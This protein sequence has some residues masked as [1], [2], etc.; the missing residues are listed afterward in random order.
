LKVTRSEWKNRKKADLLVLP[1]WEGPKGAFEAASWLK[2]L[3]P[4][5]SDFKGKL[6]E[7]LLVYVDEERVLLLGL[8]KAKTAESLRR[9][10][11][12]AVKFARAKKWTSVQFVVQELAAVE[13]IL[14][15][16]YA[17]N[18]LKGTSEKSTLLEEIGLIGFKGDLGRL[19]TMIDAIFWVRDWVN[20][21]S[22]D[23]MPARIAREVEGFASSKLK[24]K[25]LTKAEIEKE[26]MG[27]LLAVNRGSENDPRFVVLSYRGDPNSN[28]HTV[29]V[30]KGITYD[31]GGLSLKTSDGMLEMKSDMSGAATVMGTVRAAARL[32]LKVNV[33]AVAPLTENLIDGKSFKLGDV[34]RSHSGKTVEINNTDAEGRLVLADAISYAVKHLKPTRIVDIATFTVGVIIAL[35]NDISGLFTNDEKL[36]KKLMKAS[37]ETDELLWRLP[38]NPDYKEPLKSEVGD[39]LNTAGRD[40]GPIK[41]ALFLQEFAG[42]V[43]YA[44][45]DFAGP[46][47]HVKPK[48]YNP[49]Q[50][51]GY[52]VRLLLSFLS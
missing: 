11:A 52:G 23:K 17:F 50:A 41:A 24:V 37:E 15:S 12:A 40:A 49:T 22:D 51:T 21:N 34:Y 48:H 6:G 3:G 44:H 25:V 31:T 2:K 5:L 42:N 46:A 20:R 36:A 18:E 19:Q 4:A 1:F 10:Y 29:L 39:L 7:T 38:M 27:L 47:F 43:P 33:T 35:G 28:D 45:I 32:G 8:G 14:L 30:G 26:K 9:A 13:G 16:N